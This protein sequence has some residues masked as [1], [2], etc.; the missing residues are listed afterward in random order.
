MATRLSDESI[1]GSAA[2]QLSSLNLCSV[3]GRGEVQCEATRMVGLHLSYLS[4]VQLHSCA[5]KHHRHNSN[6]LQCC[7]LGVYEDI[8]TER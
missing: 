3:D 7:S 8:E 2:E 5:R 4:A 1:G 6:T